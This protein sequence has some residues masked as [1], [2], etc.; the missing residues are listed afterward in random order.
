MPEKPGGL[1]Q[2]ASSKLASTP[3]SLTGRRTV[4]RTALQSSVYVT[5]GDDAGVSELMKS[6]SDLD[7]AC[8]V[9]SASD[10]KTGPAVPTL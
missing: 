1:A 9:L 3:T 10:P 4:G 6:V 2:L 7:E 5:T 8:D